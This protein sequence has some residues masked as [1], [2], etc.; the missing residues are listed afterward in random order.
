MLPFCECGCPCSAQLLA[1]LR[2]DQAGGVLPPPRLIVLGSSK[3]KLR[4]AL[5]G[6]A[7]RRQDQENALARPS[8]T[9]TGDLGAPPRYALRVYRNGR[10][11]RKKQ[12]SFTCAHPNSP[13]TRSP[14]N[15]DASPHRPMRLSC[16]PRSLSSPGQGTVDCSNSFPYC[17]TAGMKK[18]RTRKSYPVAWLAFSVSYWRMRSTTVLNQFISSANFGSSQL[19]SVRHTR[20]LPLPAGSNR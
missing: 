8:A 9:I 18:G 19:R 1:D 4:T 6:S 17:V 11:C 12:G 20:L 10:H 16:H 15:G 14:Q 3:K 2:C 13:A 7:F 5:S